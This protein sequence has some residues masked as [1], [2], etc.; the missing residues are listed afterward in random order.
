MG[1]TK[2]N[3]REMRALL[4]AA[5]I[6]YA[7]PFTNSRTPVGKL[8][9]LDGI[10]VPPQLIETHRATMMLRHQVMGHKDATPSGDQNESPNLVILNLYPTGTDVTTI[11]YGEMT[12][13]VRGEACA[14]CDYFIAHCLLKLEPVMKRHLPEIRKRPMGRYQLCLTEPPQDWIKIFDSP[15]ICFEE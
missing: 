8:V 13:K 7:R 10:A 12:A 3:S 14:L 2:E 15:D 11:N 1:E 5:V 6:S 4:C 9:P